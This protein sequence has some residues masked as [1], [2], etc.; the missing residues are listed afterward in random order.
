MD[1][2]LFGVD[3]GCASARKTTVFGLDVAGP[4]AKAQN[5]GDVRYHS[6]R[7]YYLG[8]PRKG[9]GGGQCSPTQ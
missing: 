3:L 1:A 5:R 9:G 8:C 6:S 2:A 4:P 7:D